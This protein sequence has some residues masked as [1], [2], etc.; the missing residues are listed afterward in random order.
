MSNWQGELN[1]VKSK[2]GY[3]DPYDYV[4]KLFK[5]EESFNCLFKKCLIQDD[6]L[7][8]VRRHLGRYK[9]DFAIEEIKETQKVYKQ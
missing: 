9:K 4:E 7:L 6:Q 2:L 1:N 5:S 8:K 3:L